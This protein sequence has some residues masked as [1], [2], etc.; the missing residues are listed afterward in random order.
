[1]SFAWQRIVGLLYKQKQ[2]LQWNYRYDKKNREKEIH[3]LTNL[4]KI[5]VHKKTVLATKMSFR[6]AIEKIRAKINLSVKAENGN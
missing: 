6:I 2:S 4:S 3:Q 1:M 5:P